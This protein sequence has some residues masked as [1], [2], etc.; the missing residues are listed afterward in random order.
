M[1]D[2]MKDFLTFKKMIT[3]IIIQVLFWLGVAGTVIMGFVSLFS[4]QILMGLGMIILGP[5]GVR[6]WTEILIVLF[7]INDNLTEINNK[8]K[9][10]GQV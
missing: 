3:P 4:G 8:T 1:N 7:K 6:L 9:T 10:E 5:I 2:Q